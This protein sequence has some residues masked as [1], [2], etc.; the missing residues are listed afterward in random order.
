MLLTFNHTFESAGFCVSIRH[1]FPM[2]PF[3]THFTDFIYCLFNWYLFNCKLL[4]N[5]TKLLPLN[6]KFEERKL[7]LYIL[8]K[9]EDRSSCRGFECFTACALAV[10]GDRT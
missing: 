7:S 10:E 9:N 5:D 8:M 1:S 6:S 4:L 2:K 3:G